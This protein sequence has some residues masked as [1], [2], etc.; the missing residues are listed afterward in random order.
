MPELGLEHRRSEL[1]DQLRYLVDEI[2]AL[3]RILSR[4]HEAHITNSERGPSVKECFGAIIMRDR[5][6]ILPELKKLVGGKIPHTDQEI[7]WN[8]LPI[9]EILTQVEEAR[10]DVI[11]AVMKLDAEQWIQEV[12][13]DADLYTFLLEAS[14]KDADTLR[15]IALQLYRSP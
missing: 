10:T 5:T 11:A 1:L 6:K 9:Q 2:T 7:E 8:T 4:L 13:P 12:E 14:H 3:R 15:E